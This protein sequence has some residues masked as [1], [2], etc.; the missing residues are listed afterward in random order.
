M[1]ETKK[2]YFARWNPKGFFCKG[3]A[4]MVYFAGGK[5]IFTQKIITNPSN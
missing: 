3:T 1:G 2:K 4:K 5:D